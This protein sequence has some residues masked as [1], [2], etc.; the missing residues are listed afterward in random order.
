VPSD[1]FTIERN[2]LTTLSSTTAKP[3]NLF[4]RASDAWTEGLQRFIPPAAAA[5]PTTIDPSLS[6]DR[7]FDAV[8]RLTDRWVE[9]NRRYMKDVA[10]AFFTAQTAIREQVASI[11]GAMSEQVEAASDTVHE[12]ADRME[13]IAHEQAEAADREIRR[14]AAQAKREARKVVAQR[15]GE[16][17]KPELQSELAR[18]KLSKTG[19]VDALRA[20]L[21]DAA[22]ESASA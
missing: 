6:V 8:G 20:R 13:H 7:Y 5:L 14:R 22:L 18:R 17:T 1:R 19:N 3:D 2:T 9:L 4:T 11:G 16:M 15:F 10:G 21:I 12:Q